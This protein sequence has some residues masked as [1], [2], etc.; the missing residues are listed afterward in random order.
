MFTPQKRTVEPRDAFENTAFEQRFENV[1]GCREAA[2][3]FFGIQIPLHG[4]YH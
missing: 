3:H 1:K 4:L 2:L